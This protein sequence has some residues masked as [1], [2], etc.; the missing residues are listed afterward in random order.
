MTELNMFGTGNRDAQVSENREHRRAVKA[1]DAL[2]FLQGSLDTGP[3]AMVDD[4][5]RNIEKSIRENGGKTDYS[6]IKDQVRD[7]GE[8]ADDW[9]RDDIDSVADS[10]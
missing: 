2:R 6:R 3:C 1:I 4:I 9:V 8:Y 5:I 7:L 10:I